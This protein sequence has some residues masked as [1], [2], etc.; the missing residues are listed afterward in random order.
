MNVI[1]KIF[2]VFED[3]GSEAYFGEPV[4]QKEHA[5]QSAHQAEQEGASAALV[6]AALLHD[7][8]HL[9]HAMGEDAAQRGVDAHH[10]DAGEEWLA[11]HF[12]PEVTEPVKLHVAAKRYLCR[13]DP[14]YLTRLSP[15]SLQSLELQGGPFSE[16]QAQEFERYRY[17]REAVRLRQWDDR[18]KVPGLNVPEL[19]HYR[20]VLEAV[21]ETTKG[22]DKSRV[23]S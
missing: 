19:G 11:Q 14:A 16:Q 17:Y 1:D 18:A 13:A 20:T 4:S 3:R 21:A 10:E 15:A 9:V 7:I 5:L 22:G 12:S 8:G 2:Q 23:P 6:V